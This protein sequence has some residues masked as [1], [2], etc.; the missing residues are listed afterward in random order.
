[1][2]AIVSYRTFLRW[3][4]GG[5]S[6]RKPGKHG[7]PRTADEIRRIILLLAEETG[8]GYIICV[9]PLMFSH[10]N[11]FDQGGDVYIDHNWHNHP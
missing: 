2:I 1:L 4:A 9:I 7:R 10:D 8:W 3:L 5:R 6:P 11:I